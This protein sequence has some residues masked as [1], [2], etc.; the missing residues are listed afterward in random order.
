MPRRIYR[1]GDLVLI[2][3]L[4]VDTGYLDKESDSLEVRSESGNSHK[5]LCPVYRSHRSRYLVVE[6]PS[7]LVHPQ[8]PGIVVDPGIYR[9]EFV[10]DYVLS[11]SAD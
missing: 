4:G 3:E 1:Q 5:I 8:H 9:I 6:R 10:R 7:R 2:E 11:R